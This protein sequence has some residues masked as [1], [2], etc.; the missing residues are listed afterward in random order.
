[1]CIGDVLHTTFIIGILPFCNQ[2]PC[3]STVAGHSFICTILLRFRVVTAYDD[4]VI[5]ICKI[6]RI[7]SLRWFS[8]NDRSIKH[9]PCFAHIGSLK[10]SCFCSSCYNPCCFSEYFNIGIA[11]RKGSFSLSYFWKFT[12]R[13]FMP[14]ASSISCENDG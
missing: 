6:H 12:T 1:M 4:S 3:C 13:D 2:L 9:F 11:C 7:D 14:C 8:L 10:H 5:L